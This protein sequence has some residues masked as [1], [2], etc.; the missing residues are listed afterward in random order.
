[1]ARLIYLR[2]GN[3][4]DHGGGEYVVTRVSECSATCQPMTRKLVSVVRRSKKTG[5]KRSVERMR[6][7]GQRNFAICS[8]IEDGEVK[9]TL[10][11]EELQEFLKPENPEAESEGETT[12]GVNQE[13][14][15]TVMA[16]KG[17]ST[18]KAKGPKLPTQGRAAYIHT[19]REAKTPK[20]EAM[21]KVQA[22][23]SCPKGLFDTIWDRDSRGAGEAKPAK[24]ATKKKGPPAKV[25][26]KSKPG[27]PPP[28]RADAQIAEKKAEASTPATPEPAT[29]AEPVAAS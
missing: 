4:I 10:S 24:K 12:T 9:R 25:S 20:A 11:R 28:K 15:E 22:K 3:V 14:S 17:K 8:T 21:E 2:V 18:S 1:V 26:A 27:G 5:L 13:E 23:F 19:L 6:L 29:P 16:K 7:V